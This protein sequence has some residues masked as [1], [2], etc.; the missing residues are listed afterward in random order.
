MPTLGLKLE[1]I[2]FRE[3]TDA[4]LEFG[5]HANY[6]LRT[7]STKCEDFSDYLHALKKAVARNHIILVVGGFGKHASIVEVTGCAVGRAMLPCHPADPAQGLPEQ[8][9]EG[10]V[11]LFDI[12]GTMA[13]VVLESGEQSILL[14]SE[15]STDRTW[16]VK[17]R[18]AP[19]LAEK[20]RLLSEAAD[21]EKGN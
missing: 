7:L 16:L 6:P 11:P 3:Q 1:F 5:L 8:L 15:R 17:N 10:A 21:A 9:P 19:Y 4:R 12:D 13:G 14:L 2:Y 18:L 20:Y